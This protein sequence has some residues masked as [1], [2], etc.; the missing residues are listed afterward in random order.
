MEPDFQIAAPVADDPGQAAPAAALE[1]RFA[2]KEVLLERRTDGSVL[3][4][5]PI[6]LRGLRHLWTDPATSGGYRLQLVEPGS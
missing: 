4:R 3:L 2:P 5:S 6:E 1:V